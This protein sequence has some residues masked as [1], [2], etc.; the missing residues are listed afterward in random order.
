MFQINTGDLKD[1]YKAAVYSIAK[2]NKCYVRDANGNPI[3]DANKRPTIDVTQVDTSQLT[4]GYLLSMVDLAINQSVLQF[5]ISDGKIISNA[6]INPFM[7]LL[8][9]QDSF[10]CNAISYY[11]MLYSGDDQSPNFANGPLSKFVPITYPNPWF[12]NDGASSEF[13]DAGCSMFWI[14]SYLSLDVDKKNLIPFWDCQK[15]LYIPQ[16]QS[17]YN[18][19]YGYDVCYTEY[20]GA[21]D[22]GYPV[23]PTIFFGGGRDNVL[24]LNLPGNIPNNLA[25]FNKLDGYGSGTFKMKAVVKLNGWLAQNSTSVK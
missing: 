24:K 1:G 3:L 7:R 25:P 2:A 15:H 13:M 17:Q 5:P 11:V 16:T 9:L 8:T 10:V 12:I 19:T 14:G 21:T 23:S 20:D 18:P 22:T 4:Q 6:P